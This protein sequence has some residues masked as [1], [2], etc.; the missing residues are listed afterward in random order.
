MTVE[1]TTTAVTVALPPT[2][3]VEVTITEA[4]T[5]RPVLLLHGGGGPATVAAFA[6]R[7]AADPG[8]DAR[9]ITPTHPGFDGTPRPDGLAGIRDLA[10]LYVALLDALDL[11]DVTVVGN[12]IGGWIAAEMAIAGSPRVAGYVLV[13]AV[14]LDVPGRPVVDVFALTPAEIAQRSYHDPERFAVDPA[15]LPPEAQRTMAANRETLAVYGGRTMTDPALAARLR[16]VHAPALVVWGEAD[17]IADAEYGRAFAEAIPG[18][19]FEVLTEAGHMPQIEAPER[20]AGV[21][22]TFRARSSAPAR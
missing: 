13:D 22:R 8:A 1:S 5:G 21:L 9:V 7:L 16:T 2:A 19:G 17:R 15:A 10:A 20:L 3:A 14:G 12:S 4:G 18:A 11:V 6:E